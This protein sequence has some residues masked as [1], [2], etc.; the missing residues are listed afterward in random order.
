MSTAVGYLLGTFRLN[1]YSCGISFG[2]FPPECLQLWDI[3]WALSAWMS[4]AVGYLLGTFRLD[5]YSCRTISPFH[6]FWQG[7]PQSCDLFH[8]YEKDVIYIHKI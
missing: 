1:V 5:V 4:T 2:H 7:K 3:F 8:S 6:E